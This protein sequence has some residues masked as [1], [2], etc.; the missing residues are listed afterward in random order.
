MTN[1]VYIYDGE[2]IEWI[3]N[4]DYPDECDVIDVS[5]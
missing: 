1:D 2:C 3:K 5:V 4:V